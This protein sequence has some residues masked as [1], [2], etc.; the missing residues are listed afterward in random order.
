MTNR[1]ST[2][3]MEV[4][5]LQSTGP[6]SSPTFNNLSVTGTITGTGAATFNGGTT[7]NSANTTIQNLGATTTLIIGAINQSDGRINIAGSA[8][9]SMIIKPPANASGTLVLGLVNSSQTTPGNPTAPAST[10]A[11]TMQG[12]AGSITPGRSGSILVI[13]S[14]Y[15]VGSTVTA[16]D[17]IL[18]QMSY[19]TG[20]APSNAGALAG[21]QIGAIMQYKNENTVVAADVSQPFSM[22]SVITG[23]TVGTAVWMDIAAKSIATISSVG[24][25]GITITTIEL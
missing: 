3:T 21:T 22:Q 25:A 2:D 9:G 12:L 16:G 15:F 24:I 4:D 20:G 8:S 19:G 11:Y 18:L 14:G 23:L 7:F 1:V 6:A 13:I 10:A 5:V 17:G